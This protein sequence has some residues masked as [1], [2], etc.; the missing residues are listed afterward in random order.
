M[1]LSSKVY[2]WYNEDTSTQ[3]I[4][5]LC[6][7]RFLMASLEVPTHLLSPPEPIN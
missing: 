3:E 7:V 2:V 4:I 5:W 6:I 1:L